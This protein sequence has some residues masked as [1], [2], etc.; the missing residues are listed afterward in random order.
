MLRFKC[1]LVSYFLQKKPE[2]VKAKILE[3]LQVWSHAFRNEVS[4]KVVQ[5]T[6]NLLKMEGKA[7]LNVTAI[8]IYK[9]YQ[10]LL[11]QTQFTLDKRPKEFI[12]S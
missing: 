2:P 12:D 9:S 1:E 10:T 5:D 3:L 11:K 6:Y 8:V 7:L 4:Y